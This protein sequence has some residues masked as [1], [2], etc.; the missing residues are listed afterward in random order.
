MCHPVQKKCK[1]RPECGTECQEESDC[2]NASDNCNF[3][4]PAKL[5]CQKPI[6]CGS[7]CEESED[8]SYAVDNCLICGS[9]S[10]KCVDKPDPEPEPEPRPPPIGAIL[11]TYPN[12]RGHRFELRTG[13]YHGDTLVR[14]GIRNRYAGSIKVLPGHR[15]TIYEHP[16]FI[17]R[18]K[19]ITSNIS[20]LASWSNKVGSI[21]VY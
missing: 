2:Q 4:H 18:S 14:M 13:N 6:A 17:W 1:P 11:Y 3:C 19:D 16:S 5:K 21:K 10:K 8:C 12:Y 15:V 9:R 7:T 20:F